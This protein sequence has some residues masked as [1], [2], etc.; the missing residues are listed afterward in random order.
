M[1]H[2][3]RLT[4]TQTYTDIVK[5]QCNEVHRN[6]NLRAKNGAAQ[7]YCILNRRAKTTTTAKEKRLPTD[8]RCKF[9]IK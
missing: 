1:T 3:H 5:L 7:A 4:R 8:V 6:S 9:N 2:T